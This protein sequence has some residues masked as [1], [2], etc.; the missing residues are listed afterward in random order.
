MTHRT[1]M[2]VLALL[3]LG[4]GVAYS[5]PSEAGVPVKTFDGNPK[6]MEWILLGSFPNEK[7]ETPLPDGVEYGGYH[8]DYLESLGG[9]PNAALTLKT[10]VTYTD[11]DGKKHVVKA[12]RVTA[13]QRGEVSLNDLYPGDPNYL[14]DYAY[15]EIESPADQKVYFGFGS[16]DGT[17]I[18]LNGKLIHTVYKARAVLPQE[19]W[20]EGNL[21]KGRNRFLVKIPERIGQ[22]GFMVEMFTPAEYEKIQAILEE[23]KSLFAFQENE[24]VP[25]NKWDFMFEVGKF[26]TLQWK[27][28]QLTE[29]FVGLAPLK[30]RWFDADLN[31]VTVPAK[32]GRYAAVIE[33][34]AKDGM[35]IRR[36][37]TF[38]CRPKDWRPWRDK[39][40]AYFQ[41]LPGSPIDKQA[42]EDR[43]EKLAE[44]FGM[45]L[46]GELETKPDGAVM[47]CYLSEIKP[48]NGKKTSWLDNAAVVNDDYQLALKRKILGVENK[49]PGL[50]PPRKRNTPA[51]V[52]HEGTP[53]EAGVTEDAAE[54]IRDVCKRWY[55]ESKEPFAVLIARNGVIVFREAFGE[56]AQGQPITVDT[57]LYMASI[58]KAMTGQLFAQFMDQGLLGLDEPIGNVLPDFPTKGDK[59]ITYRNC[60]THTLDLEGHYEFGGVHN[61]WLDNVIANG[62]KYMKP[63]Q[64]TQ[65]NG[66]GYDLAG[67]AME[68]AGGKSIFRLFEENFLGPLGCKN[69][70]MDDLACA[71]YSSAEDIAR[72]AQLILNKGSYGDLEFY[73]PET[74]EK[75]L[76]T[77]LNRYFPGVRTDWGVGLV[78]RN[79]EKT[80]IGHGAASSA[81]LHVIPSQN[82][83]ISQTRNTA[84]EKYDEY[85][86]E[87]FQVIQDCI[88][89]EYPI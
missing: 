77:D 24:I 7:L 67:K 56:N 36:A 15:C 62:L 60:F 45:A 30:V 75:I 10:A 86:K 16:D 59:A 74:Y 73:S 50:K 31:E 48:L 35:K 46:V 84:G 26:P 57:P 43:R 80:A 71:T 22:W 33:T 49:Y 23:K 4:V 9:E 38:Y 82:L 17:K 28:P 70:M 19:D 61:P 76:P 44:H 20:I 79:E 83:I 3:V 85:R 89:K 47:M 54:K 2:I 6:I 5:Q 53:A 40:K 52:L 63:N 1:G 41:H 11:K 29:S 87:L 68:L 25:E 51:P 8:K 21:K 14:V 39:P 88:V 72:I 32:P 13:N 42:M 65:Y 78:W 34:R 66:M 64:K 27:N 12:R 69:T 58:T 55:A 81:I 37:M 18:W